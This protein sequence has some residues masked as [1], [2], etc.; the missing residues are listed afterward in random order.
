GQPRLVVQV[1]QARAADLGV[2]SATL[3]TTVRTAFAGVVATRYQKSDSTL[4]D[5]RLELASD[6]RNDVS[7]VGDLPIPTA[8]GQ[9]V[10]LRALSTIELSNGPTQITRRDR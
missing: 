9:T 7:R 2:S 1:D 4:E 8:G 5:V 6:A 10:P 3:G